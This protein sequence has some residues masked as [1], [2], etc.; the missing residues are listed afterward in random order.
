MN[1]KRPSKFA[2]GCGTCYSKKKEIYTL[3]GA[4]DDIEE[5]KKDKNIVRG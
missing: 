1:D 3:P 2:E 5:I 4:G